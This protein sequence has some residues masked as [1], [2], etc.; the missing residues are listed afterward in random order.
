MRNLNVLTT[1]ESVLSVLKTVT[2]QLVNLISTICIDR[3]S[4]SNSRGNCYLCTESTDN[5]L[6]IYRALNS[7]ASPLAIDGRTVILLLCC[8][9]YN[10]DGDGIERAHLQAQNVACPNVSVTRNYSLADVKPLSEY[11]ARC[12]ATNESEYLQ[13][14]EYY[15]S[16]FT[17][18]INDANSRTLYQENQMDAAN[19]SATVAQS[20]A[21]QQTMKTNKYCFNTYMN[22]PNGI[23]GKTYPVPDTNNYIYDATSGFLYDPTT[24][25]FNISYTNYFYNS[26]T[27]KYLYWDPAKLTYILLPTYES[28]ANFQQTSSA[29]TSNNQEFE[30]KQPKTEHQDFM[31]NAKIIAKEMERWAKK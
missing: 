16:Y 12:Y 10:M 21:I 27:Q 23:D 5:L 9:K 30:I 6:V 24:G 14:L 1:E 8:C 20:A 31:E 18:Q 29:I 19:A 7:L 25:L 22:I 15:H 11:A 26:Y 3:D 4:S 13:Y 2:P 28:Y 17:Q